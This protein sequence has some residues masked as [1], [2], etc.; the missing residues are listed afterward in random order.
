[1][2]KNFKYLDEKNLDYKISD[3]IYSIKK[4]AI[5]KDIIPLNNIQIIPRIE[6]LYLIRQYVNFCLV[7]EE[8]IE[9][10]KKIDK[11]FNLKRPVSQ[12]KHSFYFKPQLFYKGK[13]YIKIGEL[14]ENCYFELHYFIHV[15][16]ISIIC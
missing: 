10:I 5:I 16:V 12:N 6:E 3:I 15:D 2:S 1:M 14:K 11:D 8:I 9:T 13:D 7:N 4:K